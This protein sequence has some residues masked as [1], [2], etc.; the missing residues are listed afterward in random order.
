M[1]YTGNLKTYVQKNT[2]VYKSISIKTMRKIRYKQYLRKEI[3]LS[4]C[5]ET[6]IIRTYIILNINYKKK[7]L[8]QFSTNFVLR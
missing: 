6:K 4:D 5:V 2:S 1:V 7:I 8:K 3:A